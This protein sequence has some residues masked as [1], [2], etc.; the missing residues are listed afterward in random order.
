[1]R[2]H[3]GRTL[4]ALAGAA[5]VLALP[6]PAGAIHWPFFGGDHGR[7]GYQP[8]GEGQAPLVTLYEKT[9]PSERSVRTSIVTTTGSAQTVIQRMAYG[10]AD[11]RVHVQE[12][13]NGAP[14]GPEEG[15]DIDDG[16]GD[17]DVFGNR[18]SVS[19]A[20]TS[21]APTPGNFELGQIFAAHN[22]DNQDGV[23]DIAIA[24]IDETT[25][26][27]V[28]DVAVAGTDGF[29]IESSLTAGTGEQFLF[30]VASNGDDERLFRV[31]V[32]LPR[33]TETVIG[34]ADNTG[35]IDANPIA[36][37][38]LA[39][40]RDGPGSPF[41][42]IVVGTLRGTIRNFTVNEL[43]EGATTERLGDAVLTP[44]IP[45]TP[46]GVSPGAPNTDSGAAPFIL[47]PVATGDGGTQVMRIVQSP[48]T[49]GLAI[50][51]RSAVL[52]GAPA[53]ALATDQPVIAGVAGA[54][55][56]VVTTASNLYVLDGR[57]LTTRATFSAT[58]LGS[59]AGF[60]R[61]TA[62]VS[63]DLAYVT[64]DNGE[65]L[66]IDTGTARAVR[67]FA[68]PPGNTG[69]AAAFGQPSVTRSFVQYATDRGVFV[70]TNACGRVFS[71][72]QGADRITGG[73]EGDRVSLLAGDDF[74]DGGAGG[75]CLLGDAGADQLLGGPELDRLEGGSDNDTLRGGPGADTLVGGAGNDGL[76][77]DEGDDTITGNSGNDSLT[78]GDGADNVRGNAGNDTLTGGAGADRLEGGAGRNRYDG[79]AG[80][81]T[82]RAQN[83]ARDRI[84]CG[85]GR[86]DTARVDLRDR[87]VRCER[88]VR[89]RR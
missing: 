72:T 85:A 53:P 84:D 39:F 61:T 51:R 81:D 24:Q 8:V 70:F 5:A 28:Q 74:A 40:L 44:S 19:F 14:V 47:V 75:D 4:G 2:V 35:D 18:G 15:I 54:G 32:S 23:N 71:A 34:P 62:T 10:T 33:S 49:R 67:G 48:A 41:G 27:L 20:D 3:A 9:Q 26:R 46:G 50:D 13:P 60:S 7:S 6:A 59:P 11:G 58:P 36:S 37:P 43:A 82:I 79:G 65:L 30:F 12:L 31:P 38:S 52:P 87:V 55:V 45:V 73:I 56:I 21:G 86:R 68:Q 78:G 80:N 17:A 76:A 1:M 16:A 64:R 63:G 42:F 89:S 77:G 22:D 69:A 29:T 25:G 83:R 88:V 57:D 66:L